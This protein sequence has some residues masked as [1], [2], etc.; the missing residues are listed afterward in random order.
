MTDKQ[1]RRASKKELIEL[2]YHMSQELDRVKEE[3]EKLNARIDAYA[4]EGAKHMAVSNEERG[5]EKWMK[6]TE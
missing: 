4:A 2:L 5:N 6:K 3:N 1:L